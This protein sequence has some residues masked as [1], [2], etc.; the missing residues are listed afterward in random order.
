MGV[1]GA[2]RGC[3]KN[4]EAYNSVE[5]KWTGPLSELMYF[6]WLLRDWVSLYTAI[7]FMTCF[8]KLNEKLKKSNFHGSYV[9]QPIQHLFF[10]PVNSWKINSFCPSLPPVIWQLPLVVR[11]ARL[12]N[13]P[14]FHTHN[15]IIQPGIF[16]VKSPLRRSSEMGCEW[17]YRVRVLLLQRNLHSCFNL[18][19]VIFALRQTVEIPP[20]WV[21]T[22]PGET[23]CTGHQDFGSLPEENFNHC[24]HIIHPPVARRE[25]ILHV[26]T[27]T[28]SQKNHCDILLHNY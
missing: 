25:W 23:V 4:R 24:T 13:G 15:Q 16:C 2:R 10:F 26:V 7:V 12:Y 8:L 20:V 17:S 1:G 11:R 5:T 28:K 21:E 9:Q 3:T 18:R 6:S 14:H 19:W 22:G 27:K